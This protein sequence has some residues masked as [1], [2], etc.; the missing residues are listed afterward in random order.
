MTALDPV[1]AWAAQGLVGAVLC[2]AA[3]H[4][5]RKPQEFAGVLRDYRVLPVR[6]A[7]AVAPIVAPIELLIAGGLWIDAVHFW[8][9]AAG[10]ALLAV[11]AA[12]IGL[13]LA[14]GRREIDCGCSWGGASQPLSSWLLFRNAVLLAALGLAL[15]ERTSRDP[16]F[17]DVAVAA[18]SVV[19]LTVCYRAFETLV[20][21]LPALQ[22][23]RGTA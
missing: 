10:A 17:P 4:K 3:W 14:R 19:A 12:A 2:A 21:N 5:L 1:V 20:G 23:L 7:A 16:S 22:R 15:A 9:V 11:Y 6:L 13:N 8:A 18:G